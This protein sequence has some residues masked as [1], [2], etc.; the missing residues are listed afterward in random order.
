MVS[1]NSSHWNCP[2][3]VTPPYTEEEVWKAVA[4]LQQCITELEAKLKKETKHS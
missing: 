2:Q 4:P 1:K 3:Y